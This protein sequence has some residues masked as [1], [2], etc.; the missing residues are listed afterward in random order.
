MINDFEN[1]IWE[2]LLRAAVIK[3]SLDEL[4]DYPS[5]EIEKTVLP[6]HYD[7]KIRRLIQRL[8][9]KNAVRAS[10][11]YVR[12]IAALLFILMGISFVF[13][14]HFQY[15]KAAFSRQATVPLQS[16][17]CPVTKYKSFSLLVTL[18]LF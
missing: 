5:E 12:K 2:S 16:A 1:E 6:D 18:Q 9:Y 17:A 8:Y 7:Q 4:E 15:V 10:F 13:L 14:L 3:N 11:F